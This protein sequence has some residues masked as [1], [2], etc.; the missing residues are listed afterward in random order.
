[1]A[2][3]MQLSNIQGSV[4]TKGFEHMIELDSFDLGTSRNIKNK[5]GHQSDREYGVPNISD[6]IVSKMLDK[7]SP[8]LFEASLVGD[9][10]GEV[11]IYACGS[12]GNS[13]K[14]LE[15]TFSDAMLSHYSIAGTA[16]KE[17]DEKPYE[18]LHLNFTKVEMKYIPRNSSNQAL[19]PISAGYNLVT[20]T[21]S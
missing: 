7:S 20:A 4:S 3:Y 11:K 5:V 6:F 15:Y 14:Y 1:M 12:S 8:Y 16:N 2:I 21:K 13:D 17:V 9:S 10:L 18:I 19:A